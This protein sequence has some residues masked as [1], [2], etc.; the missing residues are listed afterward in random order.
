MTIVPEIGVPTSVKSYPMYMTESDRYTLI[1]FMT[2]K[3][4]YEQYENWMIQYSKYLDVTGIHPHIENVTNEYYDI[5]S[6]D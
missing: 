4:P 2:K 6:V 5:G 3:M 1:I